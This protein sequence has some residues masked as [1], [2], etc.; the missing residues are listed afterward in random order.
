MK[1][2][3]ELVETVNFKDWLMFEE[4]KEWIF[5]KIDLENEQVVDETIKIPKT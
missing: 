3:K 4:D 5:H 2:L 1:K